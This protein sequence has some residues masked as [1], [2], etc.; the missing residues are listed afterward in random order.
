MR[1]GPSHGVCSFVFQEACG[2]GDGS[3]EVLSVTGTMRSWST[4]GWGSGGVR[5]GALSASVA[6]M[7][8]PLYIHATNR[9]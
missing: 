3:V 2:E 6:A 5:K 1:A 8:P 7:L 4:S 9:G